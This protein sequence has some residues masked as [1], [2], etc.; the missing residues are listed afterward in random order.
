MMNPNAALAEQAKIVVGLAPAVPSGAATRR[1]TLKACER[2]TVVLQCNNATTVTGSA[3]TL[4]QAQDVSGTNEKALALTRAYV[5]L[6]AAAGDALVPLAVSNNTFTT[7]ATNSKQLLYVIEVLDG[8]LD[9]AN[10][11]KTFRVGLGAG[12]AVTVS[13]TYVLWPQNY[14]KTPL[15]S[16]VVD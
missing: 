10:G 13:A 7:D 16:A 9:V 11:F 14:S 12:T 1:V 15:P 2:A 6:D 8:D 5:L 3:V 4:Q